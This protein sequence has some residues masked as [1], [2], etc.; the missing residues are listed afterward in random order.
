MRLSRRGFLSGA[1]AASAAGVAGVTPSGA[2]AQGRHSGPRHPTLPVKAS[3]PKGTR[4]TLLG[5][6][7]GPPPDYLRTGMSSAL[8]V[9]G[10]NY[11]IDAG[12]SSVTQYLNA[13]LLFA[14]L[15][16]IFITHLHAD[17]IA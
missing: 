4:L 5:T 14:N 13:G 8:T 15:T 11:V 7:G 3:Q 2:A 1:A 6:S 17:H 10:R 9:E 16:G 12:R